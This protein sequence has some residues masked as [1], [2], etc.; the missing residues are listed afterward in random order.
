MDHDDTPL[1]RYTIIIGRRYFAA[2]FFGEVRGIAASVAICA[3]R[4]LMLNSAF[5]NREV[6]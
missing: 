5:V 3:A 1:K 2:L 4:L 6:N